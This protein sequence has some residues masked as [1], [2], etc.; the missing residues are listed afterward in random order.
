MPSGLAKSLYMV[1]AHSCFVA[2]ALPIIMKY[3]TD[4]HSILYMILAKLLNA[5]KISNE[6]CNKDWQHLSRFQF[7]WISDGFVAF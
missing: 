5:L 7:K 4:Q 1:L 2:I 3:C 6:I